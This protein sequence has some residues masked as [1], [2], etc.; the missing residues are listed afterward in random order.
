MSIKDETRQ[1]TT[2]HYKAGQDK[3]RQ[4]KTRGEKIQDLLRHEDVGWVACSWQDVHS[5][6]GTQPRQEQVELSDLIQFTISKEGKKRREKRGGGGGRREEGGRRRIGAPKTRSTNE[7]EYQ[8]PQRAGRS[9]DIT[10]RIRCFSLVRSGLVRI[11]LAVSITGPTLA[12]KIAGGSGNNHFCNFRAFLLFPSC[13]AREI[14]RMLQ[15]QMSPPLPD[16]Q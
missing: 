12:R 6:G 7:R 9:I 1:Y 11:I 2:L 8:H 15:L 16:C 5:D 10:Y 3:T 14:R 4:D 13:Q